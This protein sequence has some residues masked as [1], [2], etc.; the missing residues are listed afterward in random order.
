MCRRR[1][2]CEVE[3]LRPTGRVTSKRRGAGRTQDSMFVSSIYAHRAQRHTP[4]AKL[5]VRVGVRGTEGK[6]KGVT[7][8][9]WGISSRSGASPQTTTPGHTNI[10]MPSLLLQRQHSLISSSDTPSVLYSS[11]DLLDTILALATLGSP[12]PGV[13]I[14][15]HD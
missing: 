9:K 10:T 7:F 15:T 5:V 1:G 12:A 13:L 3:L 11:Q 14:C 8:G 4:S 2:D 6:R